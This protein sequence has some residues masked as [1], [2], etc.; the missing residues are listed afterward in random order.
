LDSSLQK[1][2]Q[3]R[4]NEITTKTYQRHQIGD[5]PFS[6]AEPLYAPATHGDMTSCNPQQP[7]GQPQGSRPGGSSATTSTPVA[8]QTRHKLIRSTPFMK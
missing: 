6:R 5:D 3:K 2:Q 8:T 1:L 4:I 7:M